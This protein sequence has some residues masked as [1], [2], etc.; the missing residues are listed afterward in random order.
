MSE[1]KFIFFY[2]G[3]FSQWYPCEFEI[4]G[5]K[6]NCTEQFMMA[7]KAKVFGDKET[8]K[9][10]M[11]TDAPWLQKKLGRGVKGFSIPLWSKASREIAYMGN[12]AKFSDPALKQILLDTGDKEIVEASPT[13]KIWGIG[14]GEEDPDRFD[15]SKWQGLNWL[16]ECIMRVRS[17]LREQ[18]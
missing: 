15:K 10:I 16:G 5:I 7:S 3:P 14:L 1:D 8:L 4:D 12:L 6:Y 9:K 18:K 17:T 13:D 2:G 11:S